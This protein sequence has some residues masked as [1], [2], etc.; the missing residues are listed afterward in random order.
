MGIS[1]IT[2]R[3]QFAKKYHTPK[4][5]FFKQVETSTDGERITFEIIIN[6]LEPRDAGNYTCQ[7]LVRGSNEHPSKDGEMIV[8][9]ECRVT[10]SCVVHYT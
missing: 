5:L 4:I 9:S 10:S 8:L 3:A 1:R 6:R 7:I 2:W